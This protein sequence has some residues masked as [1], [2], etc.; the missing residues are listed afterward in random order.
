[1]G[2]VEIEIDEEEELAFALDAVAEMALTSDQLSGQLQKLPVGFKSVM[3]SLFT[4]TSTSTNTNTSTSSSSSSSQEGVTQT[5][6][7][8]QSKS[9][10]SSSSATLKGDKKGEMEMEMEM[11]MEKVSMVRKIS[12]YG[13]DL[14]KE[15]ADRLESELQSLPFKSKRE[16]WSAVRKLITNEAEDEILGS[17]EDNKGMNMNMNMNNSSSTRGSRSRSILKKGENAFRRVR[18]AE[19]KLVERVRAS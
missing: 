1:M 13:K 6:T 15:L 11:E 14:S 10:S 19:E 4:S 3:E 7:Q 16:A 12:F 9:K 17:S 5:Q 2:D 8:T 18:K